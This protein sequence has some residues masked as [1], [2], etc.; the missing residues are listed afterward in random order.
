MAWDDADERFEP[1][2][3]PTQVVCIKATDKAILVREYGTDK[4]TWVPKSVIHDNSEVYDE[5]HEGSLVVFNWFAE[6]NGW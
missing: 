3:H 4:Q 5:G 6:E 1:F 2:E